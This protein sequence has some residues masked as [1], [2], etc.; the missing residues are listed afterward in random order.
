MNLDEKIKRINI[1]YEKYEN[2]EEY[3]EEE[4]KELWKIT[5]FLNDK[6]EE[7]L[8]DDYDFH[9]RFLD[10][11]EEKDKSEDDYE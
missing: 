10:Y 3:T 1:L 7:K 6:Y 4:I 5:K 9:V 8:Q 2:N 11:W